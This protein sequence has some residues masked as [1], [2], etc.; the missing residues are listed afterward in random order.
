[1][2]WWEGFGYETR[3]NVKNSRRFQKNDD[4]VRQGK[5]RAGK[6]FEG[7]MDLRKSRR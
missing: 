3:G 2:V 5:N 7:F 4:D 6:T 1:V